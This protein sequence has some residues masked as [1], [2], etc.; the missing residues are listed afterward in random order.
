M[1]TVEQAPPRTRPL[2]RRLG[3]TAAGNAGAWVF[4]AFVV[5][6]LASSRAIGHALSPTALVAVVTVAAAASGFMGSIAGSYGGAAEVLAGGAALDC[7]PHCPAAPAGAPWAGSPLWRS[8][9]PGA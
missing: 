4:L 2:H 7:A 3:E 5:A 1:A 6:A 8:A 9:L